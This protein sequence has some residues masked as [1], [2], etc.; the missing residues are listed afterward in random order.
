[1]SQYNELRGTVLKNNDVTTNGKLRELVGWT[2]STRN[3]V[4]GII[5]NNAETL[6]DAI[7]A[8]SEINPNVAQ[9]G[10]VDAIG[11]DVW[12]EIVVSSP[13]AVTDNGEQL[14]MDE[15]FALMRQRASQTRRGG[16]SKIAGRRE[17][18]LSDN[19]NYDLIH[20]YVG[21]ANIPKR[22]DG[23]SN[24]VLQCTT[25][26]FNR[27]TISELLEFADDCKCTGGGR[28]MISV[29]KL[30]EQ[31]ETLTGTSHWIAMDVM[32]DLIAN[33]TREMYELKPGNGYTPIPSIFID[34]E[35]NVLCETH[36]FLY[37]G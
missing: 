37:Y 24:G 22:M 21:T 25:I 27:D 26:A 11:N 16:S 14:T 28:L 36:P 17:L 19:A 8:L 34:G 32:Y 30:G 10:V 2:F 23:L 4:T 31:P 7:T 15:K 33:T 6:N 20:V 5:A 1:M 3:N 13:V 9:N 29:E 35:T 18:V 12:S